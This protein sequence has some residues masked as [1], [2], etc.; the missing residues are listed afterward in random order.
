MSKAK[1]Q[2][3]SKAAIKDSSPAT[4]KGRQKQTQTRKVVIEAELPSKAQ[5][6]RKPTKPT[7]EKAHT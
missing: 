2:E 4:E 3:K 6:I 7:L 1:P 5:A